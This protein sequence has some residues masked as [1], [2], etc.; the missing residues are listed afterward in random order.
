MFNNIHFEFVSLPRSL[1]I[2]EIP[3]HF[4]DKD[5]GMFMVPILYIKASHGVMVMIN[6]YK[7]T[8]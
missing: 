2:E 8:A 6:K 7:I 5:Y 3:E 1:N 4:E